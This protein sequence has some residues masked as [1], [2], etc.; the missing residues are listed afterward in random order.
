[1]MMSFVSCRVQLYAQ[2]SQSNDKKLI[3]KFNEHNRAQMTPAK[4][5]D[6]T[7]VSRIMS[8]LRKKKATDCCKSTPVIESD[9]SEAAPPLDV[10]DAKLDKKRLFTETS[11]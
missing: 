3:E 7:L 8:S 5:K 1:M 11:L 9:E 10:Q 6:T 2:I 4:K